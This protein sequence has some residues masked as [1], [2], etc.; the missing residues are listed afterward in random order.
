[1]AGNSVK[2]IIDL[3][4]NDNQL[5]T[6]LSKLNWED[7]LGSKGKD[8]GKILASGGEEVEQEL[9]A[10]L[11]RID[12]S[13]L[14]G[15]KEFV[16][17]QQ[18]IA[19]V[20]Q[21]SKKSIQDMLDADPSKL[22]DG[23]QGVLNLMMGLVS[24]MQDMKSPLAGWGKDA[25]R[26]V[27]SFKSLM[28][29]V[30]ALTPQFETLAKEPEKLVAAFERLTATNAFG[31]VADDV[32]KVNVGMAK[33]GQA[34]A[35][36]LNKQAEAAVRLRAEMKKLSSEEYELKVKDDKLK[37][38]FEKLAQEEEKLFEKI[39]PDVTL[40]P[41]KLDEAKQKYA[42]VVKEMIAIEKRYLQLHGKSLL[43]DVWG[44]QPGSDGYKEWMSQWE[45]A[46]K[47]GIEAIKQQI[48][49]LE[50]EIVKL[51]NEDLG[52]RIAQQLQ[53][54]EIPLHLSNDAE[55]KL[56][57]E[58]NK[59]VEN[60]NKSNA[61]KTVNVQLDERASVIEPE[62]ETSGGRPATRVAA[63][64]EERKSQLQAEL[65][66]LIKQ[67]DE[68]REEQQNAEKALSDWAIENSK[69]P[70]DNTKLTGKINAAKQAV[71]Q[72]E[73]VMSTY[74]FL[75]GNFDDPTVA[76]II[77]DA[78]V[79]METLGKGIQ[80]RQHQVLKKTENWRKQMLEQLHLEG[81]L[82]FDFGGSLLKSLNDYLAQ[83]GNEIKVSLDFDNL[84]SQLSEFTQ[85]SSVAIGGTSA[86]AQVDAKSI[87][88]V[89][90]QAIHSVF[91]GAP[92]PG[93]ATGASSNAVVSDKNA[94][95]SVV[96]FVEDSAP[97]S[98][99]ADAS[100]NIILTSETIG[101]D[102]V[103]QSLK[104]FANAPKRT[105]ESKGWNNVADWLTRK[106]IAIRD[107]NNDT[108]D[109]NIVA[110]LQ[111]ALMTQDRFGYARGA[112][113]KQNL[114]ENIKDFG[115]QKDSRTHEMMKAIG[116]AVS[117]MFGYLDLPE[118]YVQEALLRQQSMESYEH[119][120]KYGRPIATISHV[121]NKVTGSNMDDFANAGYATVTD[122]TYLKK[123]NDSIRYIEALQSQRKALSEQ[124][125]AEAKRKAEQLKT[126][127]DK[128]S[129]KGRTAAER[130]KKAKEK[131]ELAQQTPENTAKLDLAR[132]EYDEAKKQ[133]SW[134]QRD[135]DAKNAEYKQYITYKDKDGTV[136]SGLI[137]GLEQ[138]SKEDDAG[139][140]QIKADLIAYRDAIT[141][142]GEN[143]AQDAINGLEQVARDFYDKA[144][145]M[146]STLY[147]HYGDSKTFRGSVQLKNGV[148]KDVE[149][150]WDFLKIDDNDIAELWIERDIMM[151]R[152][153]ST[154]VKK[155][156]PQDREKPSYYR[157]RP[158]ENLDVRNAII[159][160]IEFEEISS[161]SEHN[162]N[163]DKNKKEYESRIAAATPEGI[164]ATRQRTL[165]DINN[166]IIEADQTINSANQF[167]STITGQEGAELQTAQNE[168]TRV[169]ERASVKTQEYNSSVERQRA[170]GFD[171]SEAQERLASSEERL[172][173]IAEESVR[174]QQKEYDDKILEFQRR[175]FDIPGDPKKKISE[176]IGLRTLLDNARNKAQTTSANRASAKEAVDAA[177]SA[178]EGVKNK[179]RDQVI[180]E[181]IND[182]HIVDKND[183][184]GIDRNRSVI[185]ARVTNRLN[186]TEAMQTW[187]TADMAFRVAKNADDEA[188]DVVRRFENQINSAESEIARLRAERD[189]ITVESLRASIRQEIDALKA[190][191]TEYEQ[192]KE[193]AG[194][195]VEEARKAKEVAESE[196]ASA[197]T[198]RDEKQ[199]VVSEIDSKRA[200]LSEAQNKKKILE[201]Q[202]N[203]YT[204]VGAI[205]AQI[206][207]IQSNNAER[208]S[209]LDELVNIPSAKVDTTKLQQLQKKQ[210]EQEQLNVILRELLKTKDPEKELSALMGEVNSSSF[211][212]FAASAKSSDLNISGFARAMY[213]YM[214]KGDEQIGTGRM[215]LSR[216]STR[217]DGIT[218]EQEVDNAINAPTQK[219]TKELNEEAKKVQSAIR[220]T[221]KGLFEEVQ[222]LT[223]IAEDESKSPRE[224][225]LA[226]GKIEI[227]LSQIAKLD[228]LF[229]A[230][231]NGTTFTP[232]LGAMTKAQ[233]QLHGGDIDYVVSHNDS[234]VVSHIKNAMKTDNESIA[235]LEGLKE[236]PKQQE[237]KAAEMAEAAKKHLELLEAQESAYNRI[238]QLK[239][240]EKELEQEIGQLRRF[241]VGDD[242]ERLAG[243]L[244][245]LQQVRNELPSY[246]SLQAKE[247]HALG[248]A[249]KIDAMLKMAYRKKNAL[250]KDDIPDL[251]TEIKNTKSY[252]LHSK[253]G[254]EAYAALVSNAVEYFKRS[255]YLRQQTAEERAKIDTELAKFDK[256]S[257]GRIEETE[258]YKKY[259][260]WL[261]QKHNEITQQA[262]LAGV[263]YD[264]QVY[265]KERLATADLRAMRNQA[266]YEYTKEG[267]AYKTSGK[268]AEIQR[269]LEEARAAA[270]AEYEENLNAYITGYHTV[271]DEIER[272]SSEI[273]GRHTQDANAKIDALKEGAASRGETLDNSIIESI[274]TEASNRADE[275]IARMQHSVREAFKRSL[276]DK[277]TADPVARQKRAE[278]EAH[279]QFQYS[280]AKKQAQLE[281]LNAIRAAEDEA[282]ERYMDSIVDEY[283]SNSGKSQLSRGAR[284]K[285]RERRSALMSDFFASDEYYTHKNSFY[286]NTANDEEQIGKERE[287]LKKT[288]WDSFRQ[289]ESSVIRSFVDSITHEKGVVKL[290][291]GASTEVRSLFRGF[292]EQYGYTSS[293]DGQTNLSEQIVRNLERVKKEKEAELKVLLEYIQSLQENLNEAY[294]YGN[295][296]RTHVRNEDLYTNIYNAT[297]ER[298]DLIA[299]RDVA[300]Q[301]LMDATADYEANKKTKKGE[302]LQPYRDTLKAAQKKYNDLENRIIE[303]Q[304]II[305]NTEAQIEQREEALHARTKTVDQQLEGARQGIARKEARLTRL[306]QRI[307]ELEAELA[308]IK[309]DPE[310]KAEVE[311]RLAYTKQSRNDLQTRLNAQKRRE[312]WLASQSTTPA[313]T[314]HS[315]AN[316]S[317]PTANTTAGSGE[318][319]DGGIIGM[320]NA[321]IKNAVGGLKTE[322]NL[323]TSDLAKEATLR[324]IANLLGGDFDFDELNHVEESANSLHRRELSPDDPLV[325]ANKAEEAANILHSALSKVDLRASVTSLTNAYQSFGQEVF[326]AEKLLRDPS[327]E[328][329]IEVARLASMGLE[330]F[331]DVD[332]LLAKMEKLR[333]KVGKNLEPQQTYD[334]KAHLYN[335][336]ADWLTQIAREVFNITDFPIDKFKQTIENIWVSEALDQGK[337][338][339][340]Q[341]GLRRDGAVKTIANRLGLKFP[342]DLETSAGQDILPPEQAM[343]TAEGIMTIGKA[344]TIINKAIGGSTAKTTVGMAKAYVK[345]I[346]ENEEAVEAAQLLYNTP[347]SEFTSRFG[348]DTK[349][350]L[351]DF[352][353]AWRSTQQAEK[354]KVPIE[355]EIVPGAVAEKIEENVAETPAKAKVEPTVENEAYK[356]AVE[357]VRSA[358]GDFDM[359]SGKTAKADLYNSLGQ[360]VKDA[361]NVLRTTKEGVTSEGNKLLE[362]MY[363]LRDA[364]THVEEKPE[365]P[366][367]SQQ[368]G[369]QL[370]LDRLES[371]GNRITALEGSDD[372]D[373]QAEREVLQAEFSELKTLVSMLG[374][375]VEGETNDTD[376]E[377][378]TDSGV[379]SQKDTTSSE[380]PPRDTDSLSGKNAAKP[381]GLIK[382]VAA[383]AK[384]NTL[385]QVVSA[386]K[387]IANRQ[388]G[389]GAPSAAGDLYNQI[390]ALLLGGSI[391]NHERL[392]YM[393]L[394]T[395]A[396]SGNVIGTVSEITDTLLTELRAKYSVSDGF[397]TQIHT[398]GNSTDPYF[399]EQDYN[400]FVKDWDA[401][402]KKQVLLTKDNI[403]VLDLTAVES[404]EKVDA[405]MQELIKAGNDAEAVKNALK[406]VNVGAIYESRRFSELNANSLV[407]MLGVRGIESKYS[408]EE[409]R[410]MA[411]NGIADA[412]EKEAA[413]MV[414]ESTG[415]SF[416]KAVERYGVNLETIT[417]KTDAK[418][419][420]TWSSEINDKVERALKE[421][422]ANIVQQNLGGVFGSGTEASKALAEYTTQYE[423]LLELINRFKANPKEDRLQKEIN[424]VLPLLDK[425]SEKL[426]SL[427]ARKDR[428]TDGKDIVATFSQDQLG[429]AKTNLHN[430]AVSKY[431][432]QNI[433]F[434][435][436]RGTNNGTEL[437]VDVL[438]DGVITQYALEVDK[439]TGQV[440]ELMVAENALANAFQNV[441]KAMRQSK[442][443]QA[444]VAIGSD[445]TQQERFMQ[446]ASS[447]EWNAYKNALTEMETYVANAWAKIQ[448]N[449]KT[450]N[451][452][453]TFSEEELDYIMSLS[454]KVIALGKDV[455]KT[456]T[457]FKNFWAQNPDDVTALNI[458]INSNGT[459]NRDEQV[460]VA[461]E[462]FAQKKAVSSNEAYEFVSFDNDKLSYKLT[463]VEGNVRKVTL[464]WNELYKQIAMVSNQS[465]AAIDPMVAN[466][467]QYDEAI[468]KAVDDGYLSGSDSDFINFKAAKQAIDNIV[469][470]VK[471]GTTSYE[472]QKGALDKLR[473]SAVDY[474]AKVSKTVSKNQKLYVGTNEVR[475]VDRQRDRI[476]GA[477]GGADAFNNSDVKLVQQYKDAYVQLHATYDKFAKEQTLHETN[478][479]EQLRQ[480]AASVHLL[481]RKL[482]TAMSQ[483][484]QLKQKVEQSGFYTDN[485]GVDHA[486][487]GTKTLDPQEVSNLE[488]S[489][490]AYAE[491]VY[492]AHI[493]NVK[494]NRVTNT[495]TGTLRTSK[496]TVADV[497]VQ[498]NSAT[499]A[500]YAYNKQERES[501]TGFPAFFKGMKAKI[502]SLLQ[503]TMG[504]SSIHRI[505][506]EARRAIQYVREIDQALTELKKV[507]DETD[508]SYKRFLTTASK[509]ASKV[510][511]TIAEVVRSTADWSRLGYSMEDAATLAESTA[512][513]LNVSEFQSIEDATSALTSTLQ[514]FGYVAEDS[515]QVVDVLNEVGKL[516]A[517]R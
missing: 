105:K 295:I 455:Q 513:L 393:N 293:G 397:N 350:K 499:R 214:S 89:V 454:E 362:K 249:T 202:R 144:G 174:T 37:Q 57:E 444:D 193:Q 221:I 466:I 149:S 166:Q 244:N 199:A 287:A 32:N 342:E 309:D 227:L 185:D 194:K 343:E 61:V 116:K 15:K 356:K 189:A 223:L 336:F 49:S 117:S 228:E 50:D 164:A 42:A 359:R 264:A 63:K 69:S 109:D 360:E 450:G 232:R 111:K 317:A 88:S 458:G 196:R 352:H 107:I 279:R 400:Q 353:G 354:S 6:Q 160:E 93:N 283:Y 289:Y 312:G 239:L 100:K 276:D 416:K 429:D 406:T 235:Y 83:P 512:V 257:Q 286:A 421:T 85:N 357:T 268:K 230:T 14:L 187:R 150:P 282:I 269:K 165:E 131:Y 258:A 344:I 366:E 128:L 331:P 314:S 392:A 374:D 369:L 198:R 485:K 114:T 364:A 209:L 212:K 259:D 101:I 280:E 161:E 504:I 390:K 151:D 205:D 500:L 296:D 370:L 517:R 487:G 245:E 474:G 183:K 71:K 78:W 456:S 271:R 452:A 300:H 220:T 40:D 490:R 267:G 262:Y 433:A 34:G 122:E 321:S 467:Q 218:L 181:L 141:S 377:E 492:G 423:K 290:K 404:V 108:P 509:T 238:I 102:D 475:S 195:D 302:E 115:V 471:N 213:S 142:L 335:Q 127:V 233:R 146:L 188:Q 288:L 375:V 413:S 381:G 340:S 460:R 261:S 265:M 247:E 156:I 378:K 184:R 17:F 484:D 396:L 84:K 45:A 123:L 315:S 35:A 453:T 64:R 106:G 171:L 182:G 33:V 486:L 104:D 482:L 170:V 20:C 386:L 75:I 420:K 255:E 437:L 16:A 376:I 62:K 345:K 398:H 275:E 134:A 339:I 438:H 494:I 65:A 186:E 385:L 81:D 465:V 158:V 136:V 176:Q 204:D 311:A 211:S 148:V 417:E 294:K 291:D 462:Q 318:V 173:N 334:V 48:K 79:Y 46:M 252:H 274:R 488:V 408:A 281:R 162:P 506:S 372:P 355:P 243:K 464:A 495:L 316:S 447:P 481:G 30:G 51:T 380:D 246:L 426:E 516:V 270:D 66:N 278:L 139:F 7:L 242:D 169:T 60:V 256:E 225:M 430:L 325:R 431:S 323:N 399:S 391:D 387:E 347:D 439:A 329:D 39:D 87:A 306:D 434:N 284:Q 468:Q 477:F 346:H 26:M 118:D 103:I 47:D 328:G 373:D 266:N 201:L 308:S 382:L 124:E 253:R 415:R 319:V 304:K 172:N 18:A 119:A 358:I 175:L 292:L 210:K 90:A 476:I 11:G 446:D 432:G 23:L 425:A 72:L 363:K 435:G 67:L 12:W 263:D 98:E 510:G 502:G 70:E 217:I 388:N 493:E 126:E 152:S 410:D 313:T 349:K 445:P 163:Y 153:R 27:S 459:S 177:S 322:V 307:T 251:D 367:P 59:I 138:R 260:E 383:L 5:R 351:M 179:I 337:T 157:S 479:Q 58:I 216:L 25:P 272:R 508:E 491:S 436:L 405:L 237:E 428:F 497:A 285:I 53:G 91:T 110:M 137:A 411:H 159:E 9:R 424:E 503:Y 299:K 250:E 326:D 132:R 55:Q 365:V 418:G 24:E 92:M 229:T 8:F 197:Q 95:N 147:T 22:E 112:Y 440:R 74:K 140:E 226:M 192:Q 371:M 41:K 248:Y 113:F 82:Q 4:V 472:E 21:D 333:G 191:I 473:Q 56:V 31:R 422:N 143:P 449:I 461:M 36:A 427:I 254:K 155:S 384:E 28:K 501:L 409:T 441:N 514:A 145:K 303:Q 297:H 44:E 379:S 324:E 469:Q 301:D 401:G 222:N 496:K 1:M 167:L 80:S 463:D 178:L 68:A 273:R 457:A 154:S 368:Q 207:E 208:Q 120:A 94:D 403:A 168:L 121:R 332:Q 133:L 38:R 10:T 443:V 54:L 219:I 361:A 73:D 240:R 125:L 470:S 43:G 442:T 419:N 99:I 97:A 13:Q 241:G 480:S 448:N 200:V 414:Q 330:Y 341:L 52:K 412:D 402:I 76:K 224:V 395:G 190:E 130:A 2:Y 320:I 77:D 505:L 298:D 86:P 498:Y 129:Q 180:Q 389:L 511:S 19:R 489:M 327:Y 277:K 135:Y 348:R 203:A 478:N 451:G 305:D 231:M 407:K 206:D 394:E 29:V 234:T 515:M 483:A 3:I 236:A 338:D 310:Q 96:T 215:L 507:T